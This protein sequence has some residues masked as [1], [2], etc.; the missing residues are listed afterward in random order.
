MQI[1]AVS[2]KQERLRYSKELPARVLRGKNKR[3]RS[4][5]YKYPADIEI[6]KPGPNHNN[7]KYK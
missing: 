3:Q 2:N 6:N 1:K 5:W 4:A 7:S